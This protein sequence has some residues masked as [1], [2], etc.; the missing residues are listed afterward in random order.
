MIHLA[1]PALDR[2]SAF[3]KLI[4][5]L[6]LALSG[7]VSALDS[8]A[9][10]SNSSASMHSAPTRA[11]PTQEPY[12]RDGGYRLAAPDVLT[13]TQMCAA[14]G[15]ARDLDK[16]FAFQIESAARDAGVDPALVH[17]V[18]AVE[19]SYQPR[20]VSPKG[21]VGLMQ[22]MPATALRYGVLDA[23]DVAGNLRAGTRH[24]RTLKEMFGDRLDLVLAAYNAGEG[25]VRKYR[26]AIPPYRETRN[27]VPAVLAR[28]NAA[29][30]APPAVAPPSGAEAAP[31]QREYLAGTR[32]DPA[33][34]SRLP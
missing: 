33:A 11:R 19:S 16:P 32:L 10:V 8:G 30:P 20:A 13:P 6:A 23:A 1:A 14:P 18:V 25:A 12:Q 5:T 4:A 17:A 34:L 9:D 24:L 27:Y 26:N 31:L 29:R 15:D 7:A 21:A 28:F 22:V 3:S 2:L